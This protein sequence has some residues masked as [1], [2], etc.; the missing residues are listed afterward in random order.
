MERLTLVKLLPS[1]LAADLTRLGD[2]ARAVMQAGADLLHIDV[3]DNH[4]VPN[5]T[6]GPQLCAALYE[7][8]PE[9]PLDV[10]LMASPVDALIHAFSKS[11]AARISI[12]PNATR[13]LDRSLT[14]IRES[15]CQAGLVLNPSTSLDC[16][17]YC[18]HH[19]DFVL[20]MTVNPGFGGQTLIPE[21][22][23]KITALHQQYP[24]LTICVDGGVNASNI[25][26]LVQAGAHEC[27][28][29]SALFN[30]T[31]DYTQTIAHLREQLAHE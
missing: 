3:M 11:G 15:G 22:I 17:E 28:V 30:S 26:H 4:Y 31:H 10:H 19:L 21:V 14:L 25:K 8:F 5:L 24:H 12:H 23:P 2:E 1:L 27:V 20:I 6:F 7:Q 9:V 18:V 29:G 16:L 13:H